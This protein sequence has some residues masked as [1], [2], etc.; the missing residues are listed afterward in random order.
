[1]GKQNRQRKI[2][3]L[4]QNNEVGNQHELLQLLLN[5]GI[6]I[7]QATLSRDCSELGVIR[8]RTTKGYRLVFPEDTPGQMIKGLVEME[9]QTIDANETTIVIK[10]LPGRAH[11]V[12]SF[13]DHFKH[14]KIL[15]TL[16]GDDTVL[17]VPASVNDIRSILEY[18]QSNLFKT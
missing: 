8:S 4:L 12:G 15:G 18:I 6:D 2:K 9:I 11:G 1:M 7:A 3:E 5:A 13:I 16:A 10:T 14:P 17:V